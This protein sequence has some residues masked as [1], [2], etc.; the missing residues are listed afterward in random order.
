MEQLSF[1]AGPDGRLLYVSSHD[2]AML[3]AYQSPSSNGLV[4]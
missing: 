2:N 3:P 1:G 4:V